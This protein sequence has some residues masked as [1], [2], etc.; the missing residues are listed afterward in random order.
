MC[1]QLSALITDKTR[2]LNSHTLTTYSTAT[3][4]SVNSDRRALARLAA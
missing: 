3:T 4:Y 2:P 1:Q